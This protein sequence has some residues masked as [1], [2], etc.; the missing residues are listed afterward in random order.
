MLHLLCSVIH[1][2]IDFPIPAQAIFLYEPYDDRYDQQ[3]QRTSALSGGLA[4]ATVAEALR[5]LGEYS[6]ASD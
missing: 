5:P 3:L 4:L 1:D 2:L 6:D